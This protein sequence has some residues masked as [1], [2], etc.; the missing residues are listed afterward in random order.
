[1]NEQNAALKP[2]VIGLDLGGTKQ[3][4]LRLVTTIRPRNMSMLV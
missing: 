1:M 2:Y 3:Q 4:P